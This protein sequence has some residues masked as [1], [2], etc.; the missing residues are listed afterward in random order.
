MTREPN[1][2]RLTQIVKRDGRV[3][4]FNQVKITQA[5]MKA[6]KETGE[7]DGNEARR[8]T[9]IVVNIVTK[10]NHKQ[11][12]TVEQIQDVVEQVLMAGGHYDTAKAYILYREKRRIVRE[13][14]RIMGVEDDL[15]MSVNALKAMASRYLAKDEKGEVIESPRQAI[16]RVAQAVARVEKSQRQKWQAAFAEMMTTFKFVPAGCYFRGAGRKKG[17]LANCF[18]LPVEDKMEAIFEAVKWTALIHQAGGGTGYNFSQ[19]RPR[20][21]V[22]GSGGFASGPISFMKAF[23]AATAVVMQGGRHR[24]ANMGIL[25]VDHPDIFEFITCKTEEGAVANFNISLGASD[26]FMK[27]VTQDRPWQLKNPRT[28]QVVQTVKARTIFDQAVALA[29]RTGDPGM[30]YLDAINRHNPVI[31]ALGPIEATNVCGEQPL[32]PFDVCNLGS[33]N[34]AKFVVGGS[35]RVDWQGLEATTKLAVR[36]LDDGIDASEYPIPQ[37]KAMAQKVRRIGLGVMGWA[38]ML[39]KL[40]VQYDSQGAVVLATKVMGAVQRA[41][42]EASAALAREKG[43]FPL[44]AKS[45]Y[46][47]KHPVLAK[48]V[49]VRNVAVTTIAPTG[50]ISM[51]ADCSSGIEPVFALS[52]VKNVVDEAGLNYTHPL[53]EAALAELPGAKFKAQ[54]IIDQVMRGTPLKLISGVP[55]EMKQIFR[56]AYDITPEWHINMQAAFQRFTDNAVSKTINFP[57]TATIDDIHRAYLLAWREGCKGITVYRDKSK[58]RQ[59]LA[60]PEITSIVPTRAVS[61]SQIRVRTLVERQEEELK[62]NPHQAKVCPECGGETTFAEGCVT[63]HACG[64]SACSA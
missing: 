62:L 38:D 47:K 18:V 28:G 6:V 41:G 26:A 29:W 21:D 64:W 5:L 32:H 35:K 52:Y 46:A 57:A 14:E 9:G 23:D 61:Q 56:T 36:F 20:G 39:L 54:A 17:L 48:K 51:I 34:L 30:I 55:Q 7:F 31:D 27:A 44:W 63:C 22:V 60:A 8:L 1:K 33:I 53:F 3:V 37:I 10:T 58:E 49:K 2:Q 24:G 16:E 43:E 13:R 42:W 40:G 4:A 19:L 11:T 25:N 15:K 12:P 45:D 50:T 59:I